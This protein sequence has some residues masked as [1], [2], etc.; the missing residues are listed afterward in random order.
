MCSCCDPRCSPYS[1]TVAR[2]AKETNR[3][4]RASLRCLSAS[5]YQAELSSNV[6]PASTRVFVIDYYLMQEASGC[7]CNCAQRAE[8]EVAQAIERIS[9]GTKDRCLAWQRGKWR[10]SSGLSRPCAPLQSLPRQR[11]RSTLNGPI[12]RHLG[13]FRVIDLDQGHLQ[14]YSGCEG[15]CVESSLESHDQ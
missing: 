15:E 4:S 11:H 1:S 6:Y 14:M 3:S 7:V 13:K 8:L 12:L 2:E 10:P 5:G 9:A